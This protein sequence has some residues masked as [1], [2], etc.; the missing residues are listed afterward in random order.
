M[1]RGSLLERFPMLQPI[2]VVTVVAAVSIVSI[3]LGI[4]VGSGISPSDLLL[5]AI[6]LGILGF[7]FITK[8]AQKLVIALPVTALFLPQLALPTGTMSTIPLSLLLA[9]VLSGMWIT[10]MLLR[11]A[12]L[13]PSPLNRPLLL[14]SGICIISL[15]WGIAWRDPI[16]I[17]WPDFIETQVGA[18]ITILMSMGAALLIGNFVTTERQLK[19]IFGAFVIGGSLMTIT[20]LL[21]I[22]QTVL[23]DRGLWGVWTVAPLLSLLIVQPNIRWHW[24]ILI[25]ALLLLNLYQT[26]VVDSDWVSGW[27]PSLIAIAALIFIRSPKVF[28]ALLPLGIL[29]LIISMG[30]FE[31][32]AQSNIDDGSLQRLQLW[33]QNWLIVKEHWLFG[34]G[35]AGYAIYY[36]TFFEDARSTHNN[37]LDI[38]SQ[39]GFVGLGTWFWLSIAGVWEGWKLSCQVRPG[40]LRTLATTATAGWVA[41]CASMMLGD[42][43]LPFAYNQG[44][45]GYKYT[46]YSWIFLGMLITIRRLV[47]LEQLDQAEPLLGKSPGYNTKGLVKLEQLERAEPYA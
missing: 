13:I 33:E 38:L 6:P 32:V 31:T 8:Y 11:G 25:A 43:M 12:K 14:F 27:L 2:L 39:F 40:F 10:A 22:S 19:I 23:N 34:T 21:Q 4:K 5:L 46:V 1:R 44:I 37:Y 3:L 41:A 18:L 15:G 16:L 28:F 9:V 35:P 17:Y 36:V 47:S 29:L 26:L 24:Q 42:W 20:Q 30:F 45:A 7:L